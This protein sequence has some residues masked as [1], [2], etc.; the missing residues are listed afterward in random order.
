LI[1]FKFENTRLNRIGDPFP[2]GGVRA[3]RKCMTEHENEIVKTLCARI[4]EEKDAKAFAE[5]VIEL[6]LLLD[7]VLGLSPGLD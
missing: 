4:N 1:G 6:N 5:L 2:D 3:S 7:K